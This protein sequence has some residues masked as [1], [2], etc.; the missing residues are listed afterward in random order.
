MSKYKSEDLRKMKDF[1]LR[2]D[3]KNKNEILKAIEK[4]DFYG[5]YYNILCQIQSMLGL[6]NNCEDPYQ[7]MLKRI[8]EQFKNINVPILEL[9]CGHYPALATKIVKEQ[10]K[11]GS[12]TVY[13][14]CLVTSQIKGVTLVKKDFSKC[15]IDM[16]KYKLI[17]AQ[18][19]ALMYDKIIDL[20]IKSKTDFIINASEYMLNLHRFYDIAMKYYDAF[21]SCTDL[22]GDRLQDE[23]IRKIG[24]RNAIIKNFFDYNNGTYVICKFKK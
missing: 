24:S 17:I 4:Q 7:I 19:P 10:I 13:D 6:Y 3:Y 21:D 23:L 5:D 22:L 18:K 16:S 20:A 8:K 15:H 2:Y 12:I 1:V 14:P 9:C 11:C